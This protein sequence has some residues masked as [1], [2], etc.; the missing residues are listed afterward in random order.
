MLRTL[1]L[2]TALEGVYRGLLSHPAD[3]VGELAGRLRLPE[4]E[5]RESLDRLVEMELLQPSPD[6]P[7]LLRAVS[8]ELA[9]D[10]VLRRHEAE[11][12][13]RQEEL[14]RSREAMA[15]TLAEL[16]A[17]RSDDPVDGAER[18]V[19]PDAVR[20]RVDE[21]ARGLTRDC[22]AIEPGGARSQAAP[23]ASPP[24]EERALGRG[25]RLATVFRDGARND[26]QTLA[27]ARRVSDLG[28]CVRTSPIVPPRMLVFDRRTVLVPL[29]RSPRGGG[30]LCTRAPGIVAPL[31]ALFEQTWAA[32]VPL[33]ADHRSGAEAGGLSSG[34]R[35]L[36]KLLASGLTDAAAGRHLGLP[37]GTVRRQMAALME[38]LNATSRFEAGLKAAQR[39]WL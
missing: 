13:R 15:R 31:V 2:D 8:P 32:A 23:G 18:L 17:L 30:A 4:N 36:L 9:F 21:L 35:K 5:V 7:G 16:V 38:R 20:R 24:W 27:Y 37:L 28:G 6:T 12:I 19:G 29:D 39:G 1:G 25:V 22:L 34:E 14:A 10:L 33:G 26:P 3:G 11:L